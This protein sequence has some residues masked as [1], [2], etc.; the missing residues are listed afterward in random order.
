MRVRFFL[1]FFVSFLPQVVLKQRRVEIITTASDTPKFHFYHRNPAVTTMIEQTDGSSDAT[2]T[3]TNGASDVTYSVLTSG[4]CA[5]TNGR[6]ETHRWETAKVLSSDPMSD[7]STHTVFRKIEPNASGEKDEKLEQ[8]REL[9]MKNLKYTFGEEAVKNYGL[10]NSSTVYQLISSGDDQRGITVFTVIKD[11]S[12]TTSNLRFFRDYTVSSS[13]LTGKLK[14][15]IRLI[16]TS[17]DQD[18]VKLAEDRVKLDVPGLVMI[19]AGNPDLEFDGKTQVMAKKAMEVIVT[20]GESVKG[21][22][23]TA[24]LW[25]SHKSDFENNNYCF[26]TKKGEIQEV[27]RNGFV[28]DCDYTVGIHGSNGSTQTGLYKGYRLRLAAMT[29]YV[30]RDSENKEAEVVVLDGEEVKILGDDAKDYIVSSNHRVT[31]NP[32]GV[33]AYG[34]KLGN[35][36]VGW[37]LDSESESEDTRHV[38]LDPVILKGLVRSKDFTFGGL[39]EGFSLGGRL[40]K[41]I[42]LESSGDYAGKSIAAEL[43][44]EFNPPPF[45]PAPSFRYQWCPGTGAAPLSLT[46]AGA[47]HG[48]CTMCSSGAIQLKS[49]ARPKC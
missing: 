41:A 5:K 36:Q 21:D 11:G 12:V 34:K 31:I 22:M 6:R 38:I 2:I 33:L 43:I 14:D 47:R 15:S 32:G 39:L 17:V 20:K 30:M 37:L 1:I 35:T 16:C 24:D 27:K 28:N 9:L 3:W 48:K 19:K 26:L 49:S 45:L 40:D 42:G 25:N 29:G 10:T 8:E 13:S 44:A 18:S 7:P 4:V 46:G 23:D